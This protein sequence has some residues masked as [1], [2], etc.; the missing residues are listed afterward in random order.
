M[1]DPIA[2]TAKLAPVE[3]TMFDVM[4]DR[5]WRFFCSTRIAVAMIAI[6]ALMVLIGTLRN[7]SVP[8]WI[9]DNI[10]GTRGIVIRWLE[11]EIFHSFIFI[12][13]LALLSVGIFIG[14]MVN[15]MPGMWTTIRNPTIRT[16]RGFLNGVTPSATVMAATPPDALIESI[17]SSLKKKRYRVFTEK[18]GADT[19]IYADKNSLGQLGTYPFHLAMIIILIGGIVGGHWGFRELEFIVPEGGRSE[20]GH[21]TGLSVELVMFTDSYAQTG[22]PEDYRSDL[23]IYKN[24]EPVKSGSITVNHPISYEN[25]TIYQSSFGQAIQVRVTDSAGNVILEDSLPMMFQSLLNPDAPAARV[26]LLPVNAQLVIIGPDSNPFNQ[27]E[28]DTLNVRSG[29]MWVQVRTANT[30]EGTMPASGIVAQGNSITLDGVTVEFIREKRFSLMQ[31]A[32]NP[33]IQL[34]IIGGLMLVGGLAAV[35]YFPLRRVRGIITASPDGGTVGQLAPL[36]KRDWSGQQDFEQLIEQLRAEQAFDI[37]VDTGK[38]AGGNAKSTDADTSEED[39]N[40]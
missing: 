22:V 39:S 34:F 32:Y 8:P 3:R 18:V 21:G 12:F 7:S 13:M 15:R 9:G 30:P 14:G 35:F 31:V 16:T 28:L 38:D 6:V 11:W 20:V 19:H 26:A 1:D 25:A 10:P 37:E 2:P 23:V 5:I 40:A 24:G 36:A 29:E 27:P 33:G 17:S 4:V